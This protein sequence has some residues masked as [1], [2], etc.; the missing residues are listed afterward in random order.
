MTRT[1]PNLLLILLVASACAAP[2]AEIPA[3][4]NTLVVVTETLMPPPVPTPTLAPTPEP[5]ATPEP[6]VVQRDAEF[7]LTDGTDLTLTCFFKEN[8]ATDKQVLET[9]LQ[10][11]VKMGAGWGIAD[12]I[13]KGSEE[14]SDIARRINLIPG[15]ENVGSGWF[16][17]RPSGAI[18]EDFFGLTVLKVPYKGKDLAV[19]VARMAN[20]DFPRERVCADIDPDIV[21]SLIT[22]QLVDIPSKP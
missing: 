10:Y 12:Y 21:Q 16:P 7:R 13:S 18:F 17:V 11:F 15:K 22:N 8:G 3:V 14:S 20:K 4:T 9:V 6:A 5:T 19:I 1:I 2:T